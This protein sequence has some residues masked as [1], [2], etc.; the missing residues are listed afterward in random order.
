VV[1][2]VDSCLV[3]VLRVGIDGNVEMDTVACSVVGVV[4]AV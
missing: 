4:D 3:G 1:G 2:R